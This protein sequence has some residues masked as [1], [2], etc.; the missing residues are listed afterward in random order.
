[1]TYDS[2][3]YKEFV[4][5]D[6]SRYTTLS[7]G[8][9]WRTKTEVKKGKGER[10][11]GNLTC[12]SESNLHAYELLF[13]YV[14]K[15]MNKKCLVKVKVCPECAVKVFYAKKKEIEKRMKKKLKKDDKE[16]KGDPV[17][18]DIIQDISKQEKSDLVTISNEE[19]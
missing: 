18:H 13:A 17:I 10:T 15:K 12:N 14:E 11:C 8:L 9:R 19:E 3:L 2:H 6:L 1:M 7:Y 4:V 16:W 5:I